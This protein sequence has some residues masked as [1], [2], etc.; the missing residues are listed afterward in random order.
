MTKAKINFEIDEE[1]LANAK[2]YV[3]KNGGSL[4]KLVTSLFATLDQDERMRGSAINP[5]TK[6]L[7]DVSAGKISILE[8]AAR[9]ELPDA[10]YVLHRLAQDKLPLPRL[11]ESELESL[12]SESFDAL[13]ECMIRPA[14]KAKRRPISAAR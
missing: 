11:S 12:A 1:I 4:N 5:A 10:G 6:V 2:A 14:P 13:S 9:L 3:A 8:A 7:L